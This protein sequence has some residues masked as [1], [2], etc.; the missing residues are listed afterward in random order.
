MSKLIKRQ[1]YVWRQYLRAWGDNKDL[2]WTYFKDLHKIEKPNMMGIAQQNFFY[3]LP[4]ITDEEEFELRKFIKSIG[5]PSIN[6]LNM[7]FIDAFTLPSKIKRINPRKPLDAETS[8]KAEGIFREMQVNTMEKAHGLFENAG[9][10]LLK[11]KSAADLHFLENEDFFF[12]TMVFLCV[13]YFRTNKMKN[14]IS[15][16][17]NAKDFPLVKFWNIIAFCMAIKLSKS[18]SL[19]PRT[20]FLFFTSKGHEF[21]TCDQPVFNIKSNV[22][23]DKGTVKDFEL[24]YPMSPT[25]ALS[26]CFDENSNNR[27]L[28][29]EAGNEVVSYFNSKIMENSEKWIF[30]GTYEQ[31][32]KDAIA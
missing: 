29:I 23:N 30:A 17:V 8:A 11:C 31:L 18:L 14:N 9:S 5:D 15:R 24:F 28:D 26:V 27:I 22:L 4:Y 25:T 10:N 13:Q 2:I 7:D 21:L 12:E 1:H 16:A 19:D 20:K 6:P 32:A 3:E